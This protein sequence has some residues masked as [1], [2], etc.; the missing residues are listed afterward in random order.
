MF[1]Q[2]KYQY[3]KKNPLKAVISNQEYAK[4][5]THKRFTEGTSQVLGQDFLYSDGRAFLHSLEEIF[6]DQIYLFHSDK[7]DPLIIDA[8]ANM[9]LSIIYFKH[10]FPQARIVAFEPDQ[11]IFNLLRQNIATRGYSHIDLRN[12][13]A[14]V[15]DT[16]LEFFSEGAL[17]GS[18]EV[19]FKKGGQKYTVPAE[20]LKN[21]LQQPVDFLKIDIEGAENTVLFDLQEDLK[22]VKHLFLEYHSV[23]GKEQM[24]GELLNIVKKAGFR[25]YIR[26]A[27]DNI[28]L[29]FT[30]R[31]RDAFD[32]QLN[33]FC[34]RK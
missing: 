18:T 28:K 31:P 2:L 5:R 29:P 25:Y 6:Q 19:D 14:W 32:L 27:F 10:L 13:A 4:A 11:K 3:F 16:H 21:W 17:A 33:I 22:N 34:Y 7:K 9:G 24:L 12:S 26:S 23:N 20:R 15:A 1:R 30:D 8:G